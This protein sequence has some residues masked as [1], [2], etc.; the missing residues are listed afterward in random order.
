MYKN[1]CS[2]WR[3]TQAFVIELL[4][5]G[6]RMCNCK[7]CRM[8]LKGVCTCSEPFSLI[9]WEQLT[10]VMVSKIGCCLP[11]RPGFCRMGIIDSSGCK[12]N[13]RLVPGAHDKP[14]YI[15]K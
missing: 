2:R 5:C 15:F 11:G 12:H 3:A 7:R 14:R 9:E 6:G 13:M 4:S 1:G 8:P 10:M